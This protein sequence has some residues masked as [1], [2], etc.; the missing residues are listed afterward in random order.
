MEGQIDGV[1]GGV[2]WVISPGYRRSPLEVE[3]TRQTMLAYK[4]VSLRLHDRLGTSHLGCVL[5]LCLIMLCYAVAV[6]ISETGEELLL[7]LAFLR[8]DTLRIAVI[9]R[10]LA[11][12]WYE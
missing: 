6:G 1:D 3:G 5:M 11:L 4:G 7:I 12:C 10:P 9:D 2:V 8:D